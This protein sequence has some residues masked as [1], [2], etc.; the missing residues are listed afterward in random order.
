ME[1]LDL[2]GLTTFYNKI[3]TIFI[4]TVNG[5]SPNNGN[6]QLA[7]SD[8]S[9]IDIYGS[10]SATAILNLNGF[11]TGIGTY[12]ESNVTYLVIAAGVPNTNCVQ[13]R[14]NDGTWQYRTYS[15]SW[16][17][18]QAVSTTIS[19]TDSSQVNNGIITAAKLSNDI[20]PSNVGIKHGTAASSSDI[21]TAIPN[22]GQIYLKHS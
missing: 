10:S 5:K 20:L 9:A 1:F 7:A 18:W 15:G 16:S 22:N 3:K 8:V 4:R 11:W 17:N 12:T 19:I 6:V 2:T 21:L 13:L 14:S